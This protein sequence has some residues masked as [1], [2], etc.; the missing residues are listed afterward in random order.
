MDYFLN[1]KIGQ[2][3][4]AVILLAVVVLVLLG[5]ASLADRMKGRGRTIA[6]VAVFLGPGLLLLAL[7]LIY[8]AIR[9]IL[10]SFMDSCAGGSSDEC[11]DK[12]RTKVAGGGLVDGQIVVQDDAVLGLCTDT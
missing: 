12:L 6:S 9:T 2:M 1:T 3:I 11:L 10:M 8:P 4:F 5:L 7:G